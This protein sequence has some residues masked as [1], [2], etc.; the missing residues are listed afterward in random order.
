MLGLRRPGE[1][2]AERL[3]AVVVPDSDLLRQRRI[4]NAGDLLRFEMEGQAVHL[5]AYKRVLG[6]EVWFEALPRTTTGKLRRHEIERRL[7]EAERRA[8]APA[9][10]EGEDAGWPADA[11]TRAA[12]DIIRSRAAGRA[13]R[14]DSNLELDLG[15]DSMERVEL[16]TEL[17][18]RFAVR[19]DRAQAHEIFTAAQLVDAVRSSTADAAAAP[20]EESWAMLLKTPLAT[21]E[22][23]RLDHLRARRPLA[24][25]LFFVLTRLLRLLIGPRAVSGREH[26]PR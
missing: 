12:V 24:V 16:L 7:R 1:P 5:P 17:E 15:L 26:L 6:Y 19:V 13:V 25:P 20:L 3:F 9:A 18:Q 23:R 8:Q 14:P 10:P 4:A 22:Q 2:S 11:H 21:D